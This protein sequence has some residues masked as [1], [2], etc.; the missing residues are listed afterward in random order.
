MAKWKKSSD[1]D[2]A[3][4]IKEK[5]IN[6]DAS[7]RDIADKVKVNKDTV[8]KTLKEDLPIIAKKSERI[9]KIIDNDKEILELWTDITLDKFRQLHKERKCQENEGWEVYELSDVK[10]MNEILDKAKT[11]VTLLWWDATDENG[12]LKDTKALDS[13][14]NLIWLD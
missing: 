5:I 4:I 14:N 9:K 2:I 7:L 1:K 11:R 8:N 6:P 13:L 3:D 10:T 12:W